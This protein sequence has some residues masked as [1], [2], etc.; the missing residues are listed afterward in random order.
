MRRVTCECCGPVGP[1]LWK[2]TKIKEQKMK[3]ELR[4]RN[5]DYYWVKVSKREEKM[6]K[7]KENK[8][9]G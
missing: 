1:W 4:G 6:E 9:V 2:K 7:I 3:I 8:V 5:N